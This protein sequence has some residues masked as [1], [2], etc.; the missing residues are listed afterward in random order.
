MDVLTTISMSQIVLTCFA[1][2]SDWRSLSVS[3]QSGDV[4]RVR[5]VRDQVIQ[6]GAGHTSRNQ[7]LRGEETQGS[8][9]YLDIGLRWSSLVGVNLRRWRFYG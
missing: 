1:V 2:V 7:D 5:S 8:K 3:V 4:D 9:T 6:E